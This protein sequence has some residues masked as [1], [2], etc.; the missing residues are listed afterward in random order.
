M[1]FRHVL[2]GFLMEFPTH[3][4]EIMK[5]VYADF[6][7]ADPEINEGLLYSTLKKLEAERLITREEA[8]DS[9][10]TRKLTHITETGKNEF[11]SW[12]ESDSD[13][14]DT[15]KFDFF[16]QYPFLEK[17]NYFKHLS[18][19][20]VKTKVEKQLSLSQKR[21]QRYEKARESMLRKGVDKYR[22]A[23]INYGIENER[24]RIAWLEGLKELADK[25]EDTA[26]WTE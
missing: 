16:Y 11:L 4:Y 10:P 20:K 14:K 15:V 25:E 26:S 7:P 17:C 5:K 6:Y 2:L 19:E 3:G 12:L 9:Q 21:L 13:E 23:I 1:G 8:V 22:I 24:L 18:P